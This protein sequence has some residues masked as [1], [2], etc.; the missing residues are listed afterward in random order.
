MVCGRTH[1]QV[2]VRLT[3]PPPALAECTDT[4]ADVRQLRR[5]GSV[6]PALELG[7]QLWSRRRQRGER[8]FFDVLRGWGSARRGPGGAFGCSYEPACVRRWRRRS[9]GFATQRAER[10]QVAGLRNHLRGAERFFSSRLQQETAPG[11]MYA[12]ATRS[13]AF[14]RSTPSYQQARRPPDVHT[15]ALH[16]ATSH[17]SRLRR[18]EVLDRVLPHPAPQP[19]ERNRVIFAGR[20]TGSGCSRRRAWPARRPRAGQGRA[21]QRQPRDNDSRRGRRRT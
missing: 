13:A 4:G 17:H 19:P 12:A 20:C 3:H 9:V 5:G 18:V 6:V 11:S 14:Q 2:L 16:A 1:L 7:L 21:H 15:I 8:E 10:Q